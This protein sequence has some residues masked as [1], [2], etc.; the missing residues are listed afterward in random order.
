MFA[1]SFLVKCCLYRSQPLQDALLAD[2]AQQRQK[3]LQARDS[4]RALLDDD[5]VP[6]RHVACSDGMTSAQCQSKR[7]RL[8]K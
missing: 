4:I 3:M 2:L 7:V 6:G 1:R 8:G 5:K